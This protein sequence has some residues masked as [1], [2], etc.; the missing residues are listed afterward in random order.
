MIIDITERKIF[1]EELTR[2]KLLL[3]DLNE[4]LENRV[5]E[6]VGNNREKDI[7]LI[8]QNRQAAL[9]EM[10]DHIAHQWK[11][12]LNS[13]SLIVQELEDSSS[14]GELTD[15]VVEEAVGRTIALVQHMAQTIDT[16]RGF[17]RPDKEKK[18]FNIKDSIDQ[19][20][21]FI[22]PAFRFHSIAVELDVD[23]GLAAFGYPKEY[24]QVLLNILANARD[25]FRA[26]GTVNPRVII[27]AFAEDTKT[28][29][30]VTDNAGGIAE[31]IIDR[32]FDFYFTTNESSGGTGIGLYMS[33]NI[34]EKNMGGTLSA[35]NTDAGALF[36]IEISPA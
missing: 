14:Y 34:I 9:G 15:E 6:E 4:T 26:R 35:E 31:T 36:R 17:Y 32:I 21:A 7:M 24:A 2:Q 30:T 27:R 29:V 19:A 25:V 1:E 23:P 3:E 5:E 13:I 10:L 20:L 22:A 12:P 33:K 28:V 11:Q 16:F 18:V 8:Q